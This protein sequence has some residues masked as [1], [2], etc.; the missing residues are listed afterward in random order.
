MDRSMDIRKP[1]GSSSP[2]NTLSPSQHRHQHQS[3]IIITSHPHTDR[4]AGLAI[5]SLF[6]RTQ[7]P[8]LILTKDPK[9]D[10]SRN[11][12]SPAFQESKNVPKNHL[13]PHHV[14]QV[15]EV[16]SEAPQGG[17]V[18]RRADKRLWKVQGRRHQV[19]CEHAAHLLKGWGGGFQFVGYDTHAAVV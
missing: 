9:Q 5:I 1:P 14:R 13:P 6:H 17:A 16:F 18:R 19:G 12:F 3:Y 15:Q 4:Q 7:Y 8:A 10:Q 2:S 11:P